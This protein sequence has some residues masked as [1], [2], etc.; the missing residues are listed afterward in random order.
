MSR[1][2]KKRP[3]PPSLPFCSAVV[4]A[5]GRSERM[6]G[7]DKIFQLLDGM[8]VLAH[9]LL[10][11]ECCS[12]VHEIIVVT[13]QESLVPAG[14]LCKTYGISKATHIIIGGNTRVESVF[15]GLRSAAPNAELIAIQDGARPFITPELAAAVIQ[16]A[17]VCGAAAPAIPVQD[18]IKTIA[19]DLFTGTPDRNTLVAVQT[20]QVFEASLIKGAIQKAL[21]EQWPITD[22]CSAVERLGMQVSF[23]DGLA[24]NIKI[25]TPADLAMAEGICTWRREEQFS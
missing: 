10:A 1:F 17:A 3:S 20:P 11:L 14:Q 23:V 25:T 24:E 19:K 8:P 5:A 12:S 9:T 2:F 21:E 18:T 13:K 15:S 16:K 6:G 7:K 4:V 22:D